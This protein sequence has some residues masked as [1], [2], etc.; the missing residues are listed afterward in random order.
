M[1]DELF[2]LNVSVLWNYVIDITIVK[3]MGKL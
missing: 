3:D 2:I 1:H